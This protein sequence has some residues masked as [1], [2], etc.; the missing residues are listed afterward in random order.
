[1]AYRAPNTYARFVKSAN[2]VAVAG[3]S[4]IM[5]LI[6]TGINYYEIANEAVSR[7]ENKP[8]DLLA[9]DNVFEILNVSKKPV[10]ASK[11][12]PNN[13]FYTE[14]KNFTL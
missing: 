1:M 10:Y 4:R 13:V 2:T 5:G 6:G 9:N 11:N 3:T 14:G 12:T 7:S 8:Y